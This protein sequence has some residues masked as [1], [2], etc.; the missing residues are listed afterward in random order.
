[1]PLEASN[2]R[3][4]KEFFFLVEITMLK[5]M[6]TITYTLAALFGLGALQA[7]AATQFP[8]IMWDA[9][10]ASEAVIGFSAKGISF[11][12]YI[13]YGLSTD[14]STW[15]RAEPDRQVDFVTLLGYIRNYFVRLEGLPANSEVFF[16]ICDHDGCGDPLYF[17]TAPAADDA[18]SP[19]VVVAGGDTRTGWTNRQKGNA[20]IAK[21]R[22]LFVMH[23][24]DFTNLNTSAEMSGFLLDWELSFSHDTIDGKDYRRIYPLIPTHGNHEDGDYRTLCK[25]FG[26]DPNKDGNC[27]DLDTFGAFNVSK[28]L[29]VYTLNSQFKNSGYAA[30]AEL[31]NQ[32]LYQ[33]LADNAGSV[34][35]R[36]AQYHKPMF[37][38]YTGKATNQELFNWWAQAF[39]D[40][41]MNLVVE[42]DT[43][44]NKLTKAIVPSGDNFTSSEAGTVYVGEGSWGAPAR[45]ANAPKSWTIDLASIQQFKVIQVTPEKMVVRTAQFDETAE[46]LTREQRSAD[47]LALPDGINWWS[48]N[49][50]GDTVN[51]IRDD[52]GLSVIENFIVGDGQQISLAASDDT[53]ISSNKADQ[54]L[55]GASE[56]LLVDNFDAEY[57]EMITLLKFDLNNLPSC[58]DPTAATLSL[59]ITNDSPATFHI[60]SAS[61]DWQEDSATWNSVGGA[62]IKGDFLAEIRPGDTGDLT[63]DLTSSGILDSWLNGGNFGLVIA[64]TGGCASVLCNGFDIHSKETGNSPVFKVSYN[65]QQTCTTDGTVEAAP[66][67]LESKAFKKDDGEKTVFR[68]TLDSN[69]SD[70]E[71]HSLTIASSGEL[72]ETKDISLVR[73]YQDVNNDGIADTTEMVGLK[74]YTSV[75]GELTFEFDTPIALSQGTNG[76]IVT[77]EF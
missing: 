29:R 68:F 43:H 50:I 14:E 77:Y 66:A 19:S 28:L 24:G 53:F 59:D 49:P 25:I 58:I 55:N 48:A 35:W 70:A 36:I 31:M 75:N 26:V 74:N 20:L 72:D 18:Q 41:R 62:A 61:Q 71:L 51:L 47:P 65:Q 21:I 60:Y 12:Q 1:M 5:P 33:D 4:V 73:L 9:N 30:K 3:S 16:R 17:R 56:G 37:P 34:K 38:H 42:S 13:L 69:L 23:G 7:N 63:V 11:D 40:H 15:T 54:N 39:Y 22:P 46:A 8:R 52:K 57:G 76:F 6:K 32:W 67:A 2:T 44:I 27:D 45:S 64:G 10:P